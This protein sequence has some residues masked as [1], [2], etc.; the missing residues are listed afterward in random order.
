MNTLRRD[1]TGGGDLS[2]AAVVIEQVRGW[3]ADYNGIAALGLRSPQQ[4]RAEVLQI[5]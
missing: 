5:C 3:I 2:S 4:Y 1:Y